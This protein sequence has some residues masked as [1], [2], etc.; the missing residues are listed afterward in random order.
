MLDIQMWHGERLKLRWEPS[1]SK[2]AAGAAKSLYRALRAACEAEGYDPDSEVWIKSPEESE[3][4]GYVGKCWHV[5]WESGP[6][7]WSCAV[8]TNE[9]WGHCETYWGFDL[10]FYK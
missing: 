4:H 9:A 5:C 7:D 8:F 2:T 3:R 6:M 10:A 1:K